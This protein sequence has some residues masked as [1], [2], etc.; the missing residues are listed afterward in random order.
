MAL[1]WSIGRNE[2]RILCIFS[3]NCLDIAS[4]ESLPVS[5]QRPFSLLI[6]IRSHSAVLYGTVPVSAFVP[7]SGGHGAPAACHCFTF[8][9]NSSRGIGTVVRPSPRFHP[10]IANLSSVKC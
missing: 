8:A 5:Y 6:S 4:P 3:H 10:H 2:L 9:E 1:Y 7:V